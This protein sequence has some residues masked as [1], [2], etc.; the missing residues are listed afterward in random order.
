MADKL[1][2]T[3][4]ARLSWPETAEVINQEIKR[5]MQNSNSNVVL[6]INARDHNIRVEVSQCYY[7]DGRKKQGCG[8]ILDEGVYCSTRAGWPV[9]V[10]ENTAVFFRAIAHKEEQK[11]ICRIH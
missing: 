3:I 1:K 7:Y 10:E 8:V 6:M 5:K 9:R 4:G 11:S 2:I